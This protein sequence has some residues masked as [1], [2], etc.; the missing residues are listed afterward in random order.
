M[1]FERTYLLRLNAEQCRTILRLDLNYNF[2]GVTKTEIDENHFQIV[3]LAVD[4]GSRF[5][6]N[7]SQT[8]SIRLAENADGSTA[9][10]IDSRPDS[11]VADDEIEVLKHALEKSIGNVWND[12]CRAKENRFPS[13][14]YA[15]PQINSGI[16]QYDNVIT[17]PSVIPQSAANQTTYSNNYTNNNQTQYSPSPYVP[18]QYSPAQNS[19]PQQIKAA[20]NKK[21]LIGV[22]V[23]ILVLIFVALVI[24]ELGITKK[25][26]K[27]V[28]SNNYYKV[29]LELNYSKNTFTMMETILYTGK[30]TTIS[31]TFKTTGNFDN[32]L[33]LTSSTV[34]SL[35]CLIYK[36]AT[37]PYLIFVD[38]S[39]YPECYLE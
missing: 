19:S 22:S 36:N 25:T 21:K 16:R 11:E 24:S 37:F 29:V 34:G 18:P 33:T 7:L 2:N 38:F 8:I 30:E 4:T 3:N 26:E 6:P 10:T 9:I 1:N 13:V 17:P 5:H 14:F 20:K 31:G 23:G 12:I 32:V 35:S 15:N 27:Y 28:G 39:S